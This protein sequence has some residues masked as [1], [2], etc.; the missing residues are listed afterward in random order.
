MKLTKE[1]T[2]IKN[3]LIKEYA[4]DDEAG[5]AILQTALEAFDLLQKS[6]SIVAKQGLTVGGDRGGIKA[7][8]LLAVIRDAR[9]QFYMGL[10]HLNFDIEPIKAIGRPPGR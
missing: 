8:P 10:K 5:L 2:K 1:A 9:G 7:H 4:I 6:Q 3:A